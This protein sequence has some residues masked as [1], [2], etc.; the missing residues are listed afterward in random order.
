VLERARNRRL[1]S[2]AQLANCIDAT[3]DVAACV[4]GVGLSDVLKRGRVAEHLDG[5]LELGQILNADQDSG[6]TTIAGDDDTLVL[7]LDAIDD[8]A[9]VVAN[10]PQ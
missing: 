6:D 2:P 10:S 5:F 8:L 3:E 4:C 9:E 7:M 1:R